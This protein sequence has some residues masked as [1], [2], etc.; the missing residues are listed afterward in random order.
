MEHYLSILKRTILNEWDNPA[1][2]DYRGK[3]YSFAEIASAIDDLHLIFKRVGV[4]EGEKIAIAAQ[5]SARWGISYL[6]ANTY[7]AIAVTILYD[8]RPEDIQ[9]LVEH[10]DAVVLITDNDVLSKMNPSEI[11]NLKA[12]VNVNDFSV[13]Y[14][15][16]EKLPEDAAKLLAEKNPCTKENFSLDFGE[17]NLEDVVA[18]NY[19]SG[20]T[21]TPK[22]IV[23]TARAISSNIIFALDTIPLGPGDTMVSMLPMAHMY[24]L[25][26]EFL[27]PL[28]AGAHVTFLGKTP[29]PTVLLQAFADVKPSLIITVP[30]VMEKIFRGKIMPVLEKPVMKVLTSVPVI[31]TLLYKKVLSSLLTTLG[32]N[33]REIIMGGAA[34]SKG[35]EN[36]MKKIKLPYVVGYGM[37]ECAPLISYA[38]HATFA[39]NSCGRPVDRMKVRIDSDD[40]HNIIGE[41]QVSGAN[42]M[43]GYYK[44]EEATADVFTADGWLRTG[45]LGVM[46]E[47]GN[48]FI[49]G[50]SKCMILSSN[51]QNIYPEEL[52]E[53]L[54][55]L[56]YI[57]DSVVV[58]RDHRLVAIVTYQKDKL[59]DATSEDIAKIMEENRKAVNKV[60]PNYSQ[61][62]KMEI[63]EGDFERTPK[64]SI[65]RRLYK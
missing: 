44:N 51:G 58:D 47:D 59:K 30:L 16:D 31:N 49:K 4:K 61:I 42:V 1:L 35:V 39:Q 24:G 41:I 54:N 6:A 53:K 2:G 60:L 36:V 46:D 29:S 63:L 50:R 32:G 33:V 37:T 9:N 62:A 13:L 3:T 27:F 48:I 25:A 21:S 11:K 45:D 64:K 43:N 23:L 22:G 19:T 56:P 65:K 26:F 18:I 12:A 15:V 8:F 28:F 7:K 5:N 14:S 55:N 52:E 40:P 17:K 10:S 20:T 57:A 34:L 38:P